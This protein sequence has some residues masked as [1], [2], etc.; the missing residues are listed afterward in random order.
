V[1]DKGTYDYPGSDTINAQQIKPQTVVDAEFRLSN[2]M[3]TI[4][5]LTGGPNGA[6]VSYY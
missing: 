6:K 2:D 1:L 4:S 3:Y 5:N